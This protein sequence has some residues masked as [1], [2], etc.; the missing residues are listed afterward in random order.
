MR[1]T[2][3]ILGSDSTATR[4]EV[5][6]IKRCPYKHLPIQALAY[7]GLVSRIKNDLAVFVDT[8]IRSSWPI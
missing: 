8:S 4:S 6:Q 5:A 7:R 3:N 2:G 1:A